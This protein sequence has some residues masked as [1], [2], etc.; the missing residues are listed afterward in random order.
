MLRIERKPR[1]IWLNI[2]NPEIKGTAS[3]NKYPDGEKG[4]RQCRYILAQK[5]SQPDAK[6]GFGHG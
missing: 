1:K 2:N 3:I 5:G 6:S 4:F